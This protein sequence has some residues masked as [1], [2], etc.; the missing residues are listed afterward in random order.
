ML[1]HL[2]PN[3]V[4]R[5]A[6]ASCLYCGSQ[7]RDDDTREHVVG[8]RF[9]PKGSLAGCWN[10]IANACRSCNNAKSALED[11]I[12]A[13]T[14]APDAAG[15]HPVSDA[16]FIEEAQRKGRRS[17]S[18]TTGR[19]VVVSHE[20]LSLKVPVGPGLDA[21][22]GLVMPPQLDQDRAFALA[23]YHVGAFFYCIT[24]QDASATGG[25]WLGDYIHF[26]LAA[27]ADWGNA[28]LVSFMK[29]VDSWLPRFHAVTAS[30]NFKAMIRRD[31]RA[32]LWAW[33]LEWN[34]N[35]RLVGFLGDFDRAKALTDGFAAPPFL[36]PMRLQNGWIR[37]RQEVPLDAVSD[38][39][40]SIPAVPDSAFYEGPAVK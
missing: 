29:A 14:M 33:A 6:N 23:R 20:E 37:L 28:R 12:S 13:I 19:P 18:R 40:F 10:V 5:L 16:Y 34:Q 32:T 26:W 3:R 2:P 9:V 31:P 39:L 8:R 36:P 11:D 21:T 7:F 25:F 30:G 22:V 4:L 15:Q 24:Y 17:V 38:T 27:K 35:Y 1:H